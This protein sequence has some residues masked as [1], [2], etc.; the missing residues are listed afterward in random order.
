MLRK[1]S[2]NN[3]FSD[4]DRLKILHR[5]F[6]RNFLWKQSQEPKSNSLGCGLDVGTDVISIKS[7]KLMTTTKNN[8]VKDFELSYFDDA[9][10]EGLEQNQDFFSLLFS[11]EKKKPVPGIFTEEIYRSLRNA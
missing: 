1:N 11:N 9:L 3:G 6:A 2:A 10:L 4:F 7:G 8:P 5:K